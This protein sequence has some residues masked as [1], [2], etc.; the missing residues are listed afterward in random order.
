MIQHTSTKTAVLLSAVL[1]AVAIMPISAPGAAQEVSGNVSVDDGESTDP[2]ATQI[3]ESMLL[4]DSGYNDETGL[5]YV[6][7]ENTGET[8]IG[9]T[10]TDAGSFMEGGEIPQTTK[11]ILPDRKTRVEVPATNV[12]GFVGVSVA[13]PN[14]LYAVPLEVDTQ[15]F[16]SAA[17]WE[18]VQI[19]GVIGFLAGFVGILL[20]GYTTKRGGRTEVDRVA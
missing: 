2:A 8:P 19:A 9:V 16:G 15:I 13:T 3:D 7:V 6:V 11:T 4:H 5:A 20:V 1:V 14:T 12:D 10:V 17:Q 18:Y